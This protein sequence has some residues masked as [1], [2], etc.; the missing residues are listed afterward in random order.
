MTV[1][2]HEFAFLPVKEY[3]GAFQIE[4]KYRVGMLNAK[5]SISEGKSG[6]IPDITRRQ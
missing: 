6:N 3:V 1:H 2:S 4:M 5:Q